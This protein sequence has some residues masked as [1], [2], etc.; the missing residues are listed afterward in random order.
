MP[1]DSMESLQA[2][3]ERTGHGATRQ[4][5]PDE[6]ENIEFAPDYQVRSLCGRRDAV[7]LS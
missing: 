4:D 1:I 2:F 3:S 7:R 5:T 6:V